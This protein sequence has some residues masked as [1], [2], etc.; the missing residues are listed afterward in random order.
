MIKLSSILQEIQIKPSIDFKK[1]YNF[2]HKHFDFPEDGNYDDI[3]FGGWDNLHDGG[4]E[5]F[6]L[7]MF[8][9]NYIEFLNKEEIA[10]LWGWAHDMISW[11]D[12]DDQMKTQIENLGLN[13]NIIY[14]YVEQIHKIQQQ[15]NK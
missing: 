13:Y 1:I 10:V 11:G 9:N 7:E 5:E 3:E 14:R 8:L 4:P 2:G 15:R 6:T 12:E